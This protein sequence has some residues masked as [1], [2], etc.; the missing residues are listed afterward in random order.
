[1][2]SAQGFPYAALAEFELA[3]THFADHPSA[4]VGL[5]N[6]LLDI[7]TET[8]LPPP[9]VTTILPPDPSI[10]P[11]QST[12]NIPIRT[13]S[14]PRHASS[15]A[16]TFPA[17]I[18]T[19]LGLP[20]STTSNT[21]IFQLSSS[22]SKVS[23]PDTHLDQPSASTLEPPHKTTTT[24]LLDRLAA[25]D[26]AYGLLSALTKLGSAWTY[27]EAW[28]ALARAYEEGGQLDKAREVL[29]WCVELEEGKGVRDWGVVGVGGYVL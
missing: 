11:S 28:Y 22:P 21:T 17:Q 27:S 10:T 16:S 25:R 23:N 19:P 3:L 20:A 13:A 2:A 24:V 8:L 6:I 18:P 4:T 14:N 15:T 9:S 26:R 29:W 5:S 12:V 1:L 7:Y